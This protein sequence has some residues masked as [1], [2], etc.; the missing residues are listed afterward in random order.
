MCSL[1][2]FF[3]VFFIMAPQDAFGF[4]IYGFNFSNWP[5]PY[6]SPQAQESLSHLAASRARWIALVPAIY[7]EN[8]SSNSFLSGENTATKTEL[9]SFIEKAK[10]SGLKIV[11]KPHIT[12]L[13]GSFRGFIEPENPE[14]WFKNYKAV[15]LYYARLAQEQGI[16]LF[17]I[18]TELSSMTKRRYEPYWRDI[19]REIRRVYKGP[20]T[21]AAWWTEWNRIGFW[22][23]LD[24]I[25]VDAYFPLGLP[26]SGGDRERLSRVWKKRYIPELKSLAFAY[27]KPVLFTEIGVTSQKEA[28]VIPWN[29]KKLNKVDLQ[30]Q[31]EYLAGFLDA[32][33]DETDW[34]AGFL[35]WIWTSDPDAG[36]LDDRGHSVQNKPALDFLTRRFKA[37]LPD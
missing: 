19:I 9:V 1:L 30:G 33:R 16:D 34:F 11:L 18:A 28:Y 26:G 5:Y 35:L 20:L 7:M 29:Y 12:V 25:G 36:G 23:E 32:F 4:R 21:Y 6:D 22:R 3:L 10:S 17:V 14:L 2:F 31:V 13:S 24:F 8:A 27:G 15:C 37:L